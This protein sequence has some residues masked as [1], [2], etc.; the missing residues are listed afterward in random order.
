MELTYSSWVDYPKERD[1]A[2][3]I[4]HVGSAKKR[5]FVCCLVDEVA[6]R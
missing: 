4:L 3:L 6:E 1:M 2:A 5:A